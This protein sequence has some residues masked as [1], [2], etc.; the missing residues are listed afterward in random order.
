M[1]AQNSL[2]ELQRQQQLNQPLM[3]TPQ[4]QQQLH[5]ALIALNNSQQQLHL[6]QQLQIQQQQV[7]QIDQRQLSSGRPPVSIQG[8]FDGLPPTKIKRKY[9]CL[10]CDHVTVNPRDHL[11][12]RIDQHGHKLKIVE[13]PLCVYACQYRQKLN[14]HLKLV[15]HTTLGSIDE[16]LGHGFGRQYSPADSDEDSDE[17]VDLSVP[18]AR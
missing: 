5:L 1:E 3:L 4:Q 2:V 16:P 7:N 9:K 10:N 18:K 14:R 17:P 8:D 11:R 6:Q 15:H 13:C 12:H